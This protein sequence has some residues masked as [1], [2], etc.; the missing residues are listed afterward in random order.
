[1]PRP[2]DH[3][4][5]DTGAIHMH[6]WFVLFQEKVKEKKAIGCCS[7]SLN[8]AVQHYDITHK[9]CLAVAW[10][11]PAPTHTWKGLT[12]LFGLIISP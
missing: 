11:A 8:N 2:N 1:M 10:Y 3:C 9:Q 7:L 5:L 4:G 12:S 6:I